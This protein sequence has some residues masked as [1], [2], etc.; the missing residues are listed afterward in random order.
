MTV[1]LKGKAREAREREMAQ[2]RDRVMKRIRE[3]EVHLD[4]IRGCLFGGAAGDALG[5]PVEFM[6]A[7]RILETY[8]PG[9]ITAY[10]LDPGSGKALI[11]DDTQM[12]LFTANGLL[13]GDTRGNLRGV[14]GPPSSYVALAYMDWLLTQEADCEEAK[15]IDRNTRKGGYSWLN[16]VPRLYSR[17]A[18]GN[19]CMSAL[20]SMKDGLPGSVEYPLNDSKGCGGVMRVAPVGLNYPNDME[21]MDRE[22]AEVAAITHG[23]P[24][25][26]MP[27]AA[28]AHIVSRIVFNRERF[29]S[30]EEIVL[31]ARDTVAKVFAGGR[32]VDEFVELLDQAVA[33]SKNGDED[34]RNMRRLGYGWVGDE[35]LAIAIYC[36]LR[37]QNDFSAAI[38][39]AVNHSGD[40]DS[41]GAIT[42][43]I[44][45]ALVG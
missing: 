34:R 5:Y 19:T 26:Y 38:I 41:T 30:L 35:A 7:E 20:I 45:G 33:L 17:R 1:N 11:S 15:R 4:A 24:L 28:L 14:Q 8:G 22:A 37:Y 42:G 21:W 25:G 6:R 9:G 31:E 27:A 16:D 29:A 3:S 39:A 13:L 40:S 43:N 23:H 18:P 44:V 32:F 10:R 36:S 2:E 12:T